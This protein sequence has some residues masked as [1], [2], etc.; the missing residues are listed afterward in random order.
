MSNAVRQRF[1]MVFPQY[2]EKYDTAFKA[3]QVIASDPGPFLGCALVWKLQVHPH[4]DS[5]DE[6]SAGIFPL[7]DFK[8]SEL[9]LPDLMVKLAYRPHDLV[10]LIIDGWPPLLLHKSV[11]A[12]GCGPGYYPRKSWFCFLLPKTVVQEAEREEPSMKY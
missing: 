3:G 9:L 1:K 6:G 5:L 7:G 10:F 4:Q 2:F 8:D 12:E 11:G